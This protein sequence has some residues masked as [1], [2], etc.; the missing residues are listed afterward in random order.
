MQ[1]QLQWIFFCLRQKK[2]SDY[3]GTLEQ[4]ILGLYN[5]GKEI[6]KGQM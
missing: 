5:P 2:E 6:D 1:L 4:G 3:H